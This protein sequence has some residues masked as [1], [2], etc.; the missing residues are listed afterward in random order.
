MKSKSM[1]LVTVMT[2]LSLILVPSRPVQAQGIALIQGRSATSLT[3]QSGGI[4]R[5]PI[6]AEPST[7]DPALMMPPKEYSVGLQLFE[8]LVQLD[9]NNNVI[10]GIASSWSSTNGIVWTFNLRN[11]VYFH[12]G[13]QV[14]AGD[15]VF[16]W[17]RAKNAGGIYAI[18]F[19]DIS[20]FSAP[21]NFSFVVTLTQPS[22]TFPTRVTMP[23]FAVI[24][25][26]AAST[27]GTNPVGAGL[28][29][30]VSWTAG[31]ITL[32][33]N[34]NYYGTPAY[35][36]GIEFK[37]YADINEEWAAFQTSNVDLTPIPVDQWNGVKTNPNVMTGPVMR[38]QSYG[39][40]V[41]A[42][43]D[44]RVRKAFQRAINGTAIASLP[45]VAP[46]HALQVANGVVAPVKKGYD[47]SG[48]TIP[49]NPTEA[50]SLLASAGWTDTNGD[51]ILDNGMGANLSVALYDD[52][53]SAS[54]HA[55]A[56][57]IANHLTNI[58]GT[59]LAVT[60]TMTTDRNVATMEQ[61]G[62]VSDYPAP[63]NDLLPFRTG[64]A[65]A[66]RFKYSSA[67]FDTHLSSALA[68]LDEAT[69]NAQFYSA[70]SQAVLNDAVVLPLYYGSMTP[71]LKRS[72]VHD[73][74]SSGQL[75]SQFLLK[76]AW[77]SA[78]ATFQDVPDTYW[79]WDFIER[80]Y[81][82]GITGGCGTSPLRYCPEGTVTR[83]QMA[84]FLLRGIHGSSYAPPPVGASTGFGDVPPDYWAAAFIKQLAAEGIT[85][86]CGNGNFCPEHPV[87]RAQMAVFLLRSKHG[88]SYTPPGVG[89]GTGFG[90][91][92]PDY[93]AAA[94]IKQL[95]T[96]GITSG[97]GS[98][99]YCPEQPVTRAQMAVFLVRTF[100]LP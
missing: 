49:Y 89:T 7:L 68:T 15:F 39:F 35:L 53:A 97:C 20:S 79:A 71:V 74:F 23:I 87:T 95:V 91:V 80:L 30:F 34:P 10:P 81:R 72:N 96:E 62:W 16:S 9:Q 66:S 59:G 65:A 40:D 46:Y 21:T 42:F 85:T 73:L 14:K 75:D 77:L 63:D 13:R 33:R 86:G 78:A 25:S 64:G 90:D 51:G 26:E 17:N 69:R 29:K 94:W 43:P 2:L 83:A 50:L 44:V 45:A 12:N 36:D 38:V 18:M 41:F 88:A 82:A 92:P 5:V 61:W 60:V 1:L 93:W 99:N 3:P 98:G 67:T 22:A 56:L 8:G 31:K 24:P 58:G 32:Q 57:A 27:I 19:D 55:T 6:L 100:G 37:I 84:V 28:F 48:I 54:V 52:P 11:D 47:N 4:L 70:D 76:Y